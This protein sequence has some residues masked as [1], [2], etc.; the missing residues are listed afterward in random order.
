[1]SFLKGIQFGVTRQ[2]AIDLAKGKDE[3]GNKAVALAIV[4]LADVVK[5]GNK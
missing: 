4:Y 3:T 5:E 1:M 2:S